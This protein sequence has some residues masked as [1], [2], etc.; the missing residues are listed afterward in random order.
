MSRP[1]A[2]GLPQFLR[3][4]TTYPAPR[5]LLEA[6]HRGPLGAY[7]IRCSMLWE[8]RGDDLVA[9]ASIGHSREEFDRYAILPLSLDLRIARAV[10]AQTVIV[11]SDPEALAPR[12]LIDND[13]W[14]R[15]IDRFEA[16]AVLRMPIV[17]GGR[18]VGALG[19]I[20]DQTWPGDDT[21]AAV[22]GSLSP[23]LG[24]WL[25]NPR[26]GLTGGATRR[27]TREWSLAFTVRQREILRQV[28]LGRSNPAI[29]ADLHVSASSV[30][31][32]LQRCMQALRSEDRL[33]AAARARSLG[34]L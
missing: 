26:S 16:A 32:D 31:Q 30:K 9:L 24:L 23:A 21:S 17:H 5:D 27:Q 15:I 3:Y 29:A 8:M 34:L 25:T 6:L 11:D 14:T 2:V 13:I 33:A 22:L 7:G 12:N 20:F 28:E 4:L 19:A 10:E 1:T 18:S